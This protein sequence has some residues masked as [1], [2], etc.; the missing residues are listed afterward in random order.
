[1][2][3]M[4]TGQPFG[5]LT[6][7]GTVTNIGIVWSLCLTGIGK[8]SGGTYTWLKL[9]DHTINVAIFCICST[10]LLNLKNQL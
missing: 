5:G 7:L 4:T 2:L 9:F 10:R 8:T 6:P 1:M 3:K